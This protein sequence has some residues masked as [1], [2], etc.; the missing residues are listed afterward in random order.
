MLAFGPIQAVK[1]HGPTPR[2][3]DVAIPAAVV[4]LMPRLGCLIQVDIVA[5]LIEVVIKAVSCNTGTSP[6]R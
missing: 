4:D 2:R 6:T 3:M 5:L 1:N